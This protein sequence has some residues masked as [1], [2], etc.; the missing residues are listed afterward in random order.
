MTKFL[1]SLVLIAI[2][3][4]ALATVLPPHRYVIPPLTPWRQNVDEARYEAILRKLYQTHIGSIQARGQ[5]LRIDKDWMDGT[6]N[7]F[8]DRDGNTLIIEAPGGLARHPLITPDAFMLLLCHEMGH[9]LGGY[10]AGMPGAWPSNEGQSDY[11]S[12]LKCLRRMF[13]DEDNAAALQGQTLD[14]VLVSRC[15]TAYP[16]KRLEQLMCVRSGLAAMSAVQFFYSFDRRGPPPSFS[17]PDPTVVP[18]T[19]S[20]HARPACRLDTMMAGALCKADPRVNPDPIN[21]FSGVCSSAFDP[22]GARPACW[23][24]EPQQPTRRF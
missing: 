14:P 2:S 11:F 5:R 16:G 19:S 24:R 13:Y 8:A 10:P 23:F 18:A 22:A 1:L 4:N 6:A 21:P 3:S 17:Q 12:T 7:A 15:S 9:H 20:A